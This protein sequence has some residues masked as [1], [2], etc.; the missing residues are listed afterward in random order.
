MTPWSTPVM[1]LRGSATFSSLSNRNYRLFMVGQCGSMVGTAMQAVAQSWLILKLTGSGT[2]L[3]VTVSLQYLPVLFLSG[4]AGVLLDRADRRRMLFLIQVLGGAQAL[5][6]GVMTITGTIRLPTVY[7]FA[8][9]LGLIN[10][11]E[12]PLRQLF[13]FD[14]VDGENVS[15]AIALSMALNNISKFVGPAAAGMAI[16]AIGIGPCFLLNAVSFVAMMVA[17]ARIRADE[18]RTT[19]PQPRRPGQ[20]REGLRYVRRSP[21]LLGPL[22]VLG[23]LF[24]L[25]WQYE[26]LLPLF[27]RYSF[28]GGAGMYGT[29]TAVVAV[30]CLIGGLMMASR[31]AVTDRMIMWSL[32]AVAACQ[33]TLAATRWFPAALLVLTFSG[34]AGIT[35][36]GA[37]NSLLQ[38]RSTP[39]MRG[40]VMGLYA[41]AII[42]TRPIGG[43]IVGFVAERTGPRWCLVFCGVAVL[44]VTLPLWAALN[45][46]AARSPGHGLRIPAVV[47]TEPA[48]LPTLPIS[49]TVDAFDR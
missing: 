33:F 36:A 38:V 41:I 27:A 14:V 22:V 6:L 46:A 19:A 37:C 35:A 47:R 44:V 25:S 9:T 13:I 31:P 24:G 32:V 2:A 16:G 49:V 28:H 21:A 42:G 23:M 17:V 7:A 30:G 43:P 8:A 10:C 18:L 39:E 11:I 34:V 1:R 40:R 5:A 12:Q 48:S 3:G 29:M 26:V 4:P 15:N 45:R 20:F